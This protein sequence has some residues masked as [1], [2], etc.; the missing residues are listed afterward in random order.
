V[1]LIGLI[2]NLATKF[3]SYASLG[4]P[5]GMQILS[6]FVILRFRPFET[7]TNSN[8]LAVKAETKKL[9]AR[10]TA[11]FNPPISPIASSMP[12]TVRE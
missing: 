5:L 2:L 11:S 9:R 12:Y 8:Y 3:D 10:K 1:L 7:E 4:G 6:L